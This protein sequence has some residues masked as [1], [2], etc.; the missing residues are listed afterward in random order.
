M[1]TSLGISTLYQAMAM[2]AAQVVTLEGCPQI[3]AI[4]QK[5]FKDLSVQNIELMTGDF[6]KTLPLALKKLN[7][8][9]YAFF[10][11][12]HRKA[13]TLSYFEQALPYVH[14]N[15]I[16]G[17][18][19]SMLSTSCSRKPEKEKKEKNSQGYTL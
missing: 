5:G 16:F 19:L 15:S 2:Q 10:D 14:E 7:Q 6:A 8:L 17:T 12:N 9:D 1:G 13:P 3:S 4:A 18:Y 11:G